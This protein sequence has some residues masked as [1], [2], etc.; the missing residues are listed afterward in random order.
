M[1]ANLRTIGS[2]IGTAL[3]T[4]IVTGTAAVTGEPTEAG[5][6]T[7]FL[8]LAAFAVGAVV[9]ALVGRTHRVHQAQPDVPAVLVGA[10]TV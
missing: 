4:V 1:N 9:L 6:T 7:G 10:D 5:Y 8:V 2:S 3:M